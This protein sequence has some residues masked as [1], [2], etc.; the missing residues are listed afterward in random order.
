MNT[1]AGKTIRNSK[2]DQERKEPSLLSSIISE[3]NYQPTPSN[4]NQLEKNSKK[5]EEKVVIQLAPILSSCGDDQEPRTNDQDDG[6]DV[7]MIKKAEQLKN[8]DF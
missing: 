5:A 4:D 1:A 6:K 7:T 3:M 8:D 2:D